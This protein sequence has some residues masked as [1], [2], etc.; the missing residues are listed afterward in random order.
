MYL[1]FKVHFVLPFLF[2]NLTQGISKIIS[3]F[4]FSITGTDTYLKKG[5]NA[6]ST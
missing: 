5:F 2:K 4:F 6:Q 1:S 3:L